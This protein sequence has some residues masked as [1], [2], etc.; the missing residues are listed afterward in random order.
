MTNDPSVGRAFIAQA[1]EFLASEYLPK[2]ERCL[3][4]LDDNQIWWR[5]NPQSNSI[6]NL[7]LHL[8]GNARQW[9]ICGLGG[10]DDQRYRDAEFAQTDII[11]RAKLAELLRTT[12]AE[13]GAVLKRID[14]GTLLDERKIQGTGVNVLHAIFHVT[15]HFSMHTGQILMLTKMLTARDLKFYDFRDGVPVHRWAL[16]I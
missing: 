14:A 15:E 10:A 1:Y 13:V 8:C 11:E 4:Q 2:I 16:D 7:I 5:A 12:V 3:E 9:I 6:G